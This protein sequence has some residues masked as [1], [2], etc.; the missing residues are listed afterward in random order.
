[1]RRI[2]CGNTYEKWRHL[3][4]NHEIMLEG[5]LLAAQNAEM[6][7]YAAWQESCAAVFRTRAA[8]EAA[9]NRR[10]AVQNELELFLEEAR[11]VA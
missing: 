8:Y 1:M 7:A 9:Q 10:L 11:H 2:D 5:K 4:G 3:V 6:Q